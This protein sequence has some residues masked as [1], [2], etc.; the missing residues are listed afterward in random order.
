MLQLGQKV[1][2]IGDG[3]EQNLPIGEYGFVI[4]YE[5]NPDNVFDYL[6]RV[7]KLNRHIFVLADD[8]ELEEVMLAQEADR[9]ER[10]A[11]IDFALATKNEELFKRVMNG[12]RVEPLQESAKEVSSREDFIKQIN[13]KAWI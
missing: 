7:P 10:D 11:I 5:R 8:I 9:I 2:I 13:L 3:L 12:D 4:A 6:V 1:L